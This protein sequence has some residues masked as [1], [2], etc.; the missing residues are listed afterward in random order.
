MGV[1]VVT[2]ILTLAGVLAISVIGKVRNRL[3][4]QA[5][6]EAITELRVSPAR[7]SRPVAAASIAAEVAVL[8][9]VLWP[10][11]AA[12]GL[13]VAVLL[14]GAFAWALARAVRR[15]SAAGCHCFGPSETPVAWRH[16]GRSGF[17]AAAAAGALVG[18]VAHPGLSLA[19]LTPPQ[20]ILALALAGVI[21]T[22]LVRLD[23]LT[24][25]FRGAEHAR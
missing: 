18:T 16:V 3:S 2:T 6:A 17:L 24:W 10:G 22:T 1:A 15:G 7:W 20:F 23:D 25:L 12:V 4:F 13:A 19:G 9:L 5:F 14:F 21:I 8:T 11:G